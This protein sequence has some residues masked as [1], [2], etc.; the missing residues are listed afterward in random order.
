[1]TLGGGWRTWAVLAFQLAA[2]FVLVAMVPAFMVFEVRAEARA[3]Q[4]EWAISGPPCDVIEP[5]ASSASS[6]ADPQARFTYGGARFSG[7]FDAV[8]CAAVP[9]TWWWP[10][11]L[12]RVCMFSG[13]GALTVTTTDGPLTFRPPQGQSATITIRDGRANCVVGG[14]PTL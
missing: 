13:P 4:S 5:P 8:S 9:S 12:Y 14:K 2:T 7:H 1:M 3:L 6:R 10:K 11:D